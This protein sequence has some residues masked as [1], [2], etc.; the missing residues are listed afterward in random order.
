[1]HSFSNLP[2]V[3]SIFSI[4]HIMQLLEKSRYAVVSEDLTQETTAK[5]LKKLRR[6]FV[7]V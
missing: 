4:A 7:V 3:S 5:I 1:M 2:N 6:I